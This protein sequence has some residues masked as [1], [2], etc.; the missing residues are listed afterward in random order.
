MGESTTAAGGFAV[1][2]E[3]SSQLIRLVET[4]GVAPSVMQNVPMASDTLLVPKRLT[5]VTAAW[6]GENSE[7]TTSDPT[8]TQVQLVAK[9]LASGTRVARE[10][11]LDSVIAVADW[12]VQEHS[13]ALAKKTDEAAFNGDGTSTFRR[14]PGYHDQ[15]QRRQSHCWRGCGRSWQQQ[16]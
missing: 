7:I 1:P 6:I 10:L 2:E 13:L 8:G 14:H 12:L 4:Y 11:L 5:G 9:K 16:L 15:D 3:M